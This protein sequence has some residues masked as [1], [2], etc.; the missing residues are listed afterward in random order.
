MLK[1]ISLGLILTGSLTTLMADNNPSIPVIQLSG[2]QQNVDITLPANATTGYQWYVVGYDHNL[3]SL[4]NYRYA[5]P[6]NTKLMGAPGQAVFTFTIDPSFFN[7]PQSTE[8]K[9]SYQ[10]PNSPVQDA[11]LTTVTVSSLASQNDS[12]SWEKH[13]ASNGTEVV[14]KNA[15]QEAADPNWISLPPIHG[16]S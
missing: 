14:I 11:T 1:K 2:D 7:A 8:V 9:L 13:P 15:A 10:R 3:L 6:S 12:S 16:N 5:P 4:N